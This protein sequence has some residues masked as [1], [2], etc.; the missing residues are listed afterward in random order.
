MPSGVVLD[1]VVASEVIAALGI[2]R[3]QAAPA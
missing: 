2:N 3:T 1:K